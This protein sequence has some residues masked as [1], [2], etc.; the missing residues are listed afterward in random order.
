MNST[1]HHTLSLDVALMCSA[2]EWRGSTASF[3]KI[4]AGLM[5]RGHRP[6]LITASASMEDRFRAL[7]LDAV[8]L[9][10]PKT[11]AREIMTI[12]RVLG[13]S[14]ARVVM[15]DTPRDLR[16]AASASFFTGRPI[17]YRYNRYAPDQRLDL[18][19]RFFLRQVDACVF[20]SEFIET[21][22]LGDA[23]LLRRARRYR[24]PNGVDLELFTAKPDAGSRFRDTHGL[25]PDTFLVVT[26]SKLTANKE[27]DVAL[28]ALA[29]VRAGGH[30]VVYVLCGEGAQAGTLRQSADELRVPVLFTGQLDPEGMVAALS[31]ADVVVHPAP[32]EIFPNIVAEAM[33]CARPVIGIDSSGVPE[34]LGPDQEAGL[35]VP[36]ADPVAMAAAVV[37]LLNDPE[38]RRRLGHAAR[39]RVA[40]EFPLHRMEEGYTRMFLEEVQGVASGPARRS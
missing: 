31:A 13:H 7:G 15:V 2:A 19:D 34:V 32:I 22:A 37:R 28:D 11:G 20:Q 27:V 30:D 9:H 5:R 1:E 24:I 33:A 17:V 26:G 38:L 23:P 35:L 36:P 6:L 18:S 4:A 21:K 25:S 29:R 16:L 39:T 40:R 3:A 14:N 8:G 12:R 10:L